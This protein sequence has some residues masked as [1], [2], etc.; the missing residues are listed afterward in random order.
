MVWPALNSLG[1]RSSFLLIGGWWFP[2]L[3][4][5]GSSFA[6]SETWFAL[7]DERADLRCGLWVSY[8]KEYCSWYTANIVNISVFNA[9]S[10]GGGIVAAVLLR[11]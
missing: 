6:W 3:R 9:L 8:P 5:G 7:L 4:S 2:I 10:I 11:M 1:I